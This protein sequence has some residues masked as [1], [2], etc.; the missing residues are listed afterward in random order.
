MIKL[1][2]SIFFLV[3]HLGSHYPYDWLLDW[4]D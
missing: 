4:L 2:L 1:A 3:L